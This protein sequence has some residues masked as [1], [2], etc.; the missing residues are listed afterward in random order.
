MRQEVKGAS[1][2][3]PKVISKPQKG[4]GFML[5]YRGEKELKRK[6]FI[7]AVKDLLK[8][9]KELLLKK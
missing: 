1:P 4:M 3:F 5:I 8:R 9:L 7:R 6:L 2:R